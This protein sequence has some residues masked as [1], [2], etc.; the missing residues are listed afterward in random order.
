MAED[1]SGAPTAPE[2]HVELA[3]PDR[4][5]LLVDWLNELLYRSELHKCVYGDVRVERASDRR[6]AATLRGREPTWP[7]TQ[8]KAATW[9]RVRVRD[10]P[11]GLDATVVIDV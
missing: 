11:G 10:T 5:L 1:A 8:V 7:R 4:E 6:L 9:H 3:A 2:E